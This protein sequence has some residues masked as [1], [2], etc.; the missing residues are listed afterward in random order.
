MTTRKALLLAC[1]AIAVLAMST[2]AAS[3]S[4]RYWWLDHEITEGYPGPENKKEETPMGELSITVGGAEFGC[5]FVMKVTVW[6]EPAGMGEG[7]VE[8]QFGEAENC[9]TNLPGCTLEK[10]ELTGFPWNVTLEMGEIVVIS[11]ISIKSHLSKKCQE[12]YGLPLTPTATGAVE[13]QFVD[14]FKAEGGGE[15]LPA[16]LQFDKSPGLT[17]NGT[18]PATLDG[19][20]EFGTQ[21]TA[22]LIPH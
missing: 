16:T 2:S 13:G 19:T 20:L 9:K 8:Q 4:H 18:L 5:K 3:E 1:M 14:Y 22:E 21:V 15:D 17:V 11:G 7:N 6:N 10:S 12:T